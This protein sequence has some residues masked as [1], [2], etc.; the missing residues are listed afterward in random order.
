MWCYTLGE[1]ERCVYQPGEVAYLAK[2]AAKGYRIPDHV[3]MLE[4]ARGPIALMLP[5]GLVDTVLSTLDY[6]VIAQT[7]WHYGRAATREL[8]SNHKI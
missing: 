1:F 4:Y 8:F 5:F 7:I 2:S 6:G 3:W